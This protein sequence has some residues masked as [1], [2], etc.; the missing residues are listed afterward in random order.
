MTKTKHHGGM[1]FK[2]FTTFNLSLLTKMAESIVNE[3]DVLWVQVLK[4]LYL[5]K[6]DFV[7]ATKGARASW[8]WMRFLEGRDLLR[9][10]GFWVVGDENKIN[11]VRDAC[12]YKGKK[13]D[14]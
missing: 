2:E 11:L 14:I 7:R 6:G 12:I 4:E 1:G 8:G 10:I 13:S 5:A 3:S 9:G